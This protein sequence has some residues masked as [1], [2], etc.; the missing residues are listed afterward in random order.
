MTVIGIN[1]NPAEVLAIAPVVRF[2]RFDSFGSAEDDDGTA[3][4]PSTTPM[5]LS[6]F[7]RATFCRSALR[8]VKYSADPKPVRSADGAV[9]RQKP[10]M[11]L[12]PDRISRKEARREAEPDCWTRVLRRSAGWRRTAERRPEP[13]PAVKWK[14]VVVVT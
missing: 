3:V 10:R 8:L 13:S 9:P 7:E 14:A 6:R 11:A 4:A 2:A 12:G 5:L 1:T